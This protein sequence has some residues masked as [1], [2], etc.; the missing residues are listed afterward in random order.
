MKLKFLLPVAVIIITFYSC[1]KHDTPGPV[2]RYP[3]DVANAWMQ[4]QIRLTKST[5]GYNSVVSDRSFA[6]AGITLY[7]SLVP[8]I[9]GYRS[10]L[11][12]IGGS[13]VL[14]NK[15]N[16]QYYWPASVN[17]AMAMLTKSFFETTSPA[18]MA[19][20][21]SLETAYASTFQTQSDAVKIQNAVDYGHQVAT[22]IFNWSKTDG[23]HQ[24]YRHIVDS[25][26]MPPVG[27]G[28][29]VPT[30]PAFGPP[31]HPHWGNNR[32]FIANVA[33]STL[34]GAPTPYSTSPHSS[35]Y[36]MVN[37]L[38]TISLS[39]SHEDSVISK[40]WG[41][42]PGNLNVPAHATN[43]LYQL[44][45]TNKLDLG[46]AAVAY[47]LHGIALNDAAISVLKTKYQYNLIRPITYIRNVM[48]H[49]TWASVLPTPPHPEYSAGHAVV[50]AAS[51][52]VLEKIFGKNYLLKTDNPLLGSYYNHLRQFKIICRVVDTL[53]LA[54]NL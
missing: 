3:A 53:E 26:Y 16:D 54:F 38:Y 40:F 18:N 7:E 10:L 46:A 42:Q 22:A 24:A 6:Y 27:D 41:D 11:P 17:A 33:A 36:E 5:T 8:G 31:V 25:S 2:G 28:L 50:S 30:F 37:E 14:T 39:L 4:M 49:P 32:S 34:P 20:I 15:S 52:A 43:I 19:S 29:W 21:D 9:P 13:A 12:Q 23:G 48:L 47:A 35:F 1:K 44:I 45:I 51:A